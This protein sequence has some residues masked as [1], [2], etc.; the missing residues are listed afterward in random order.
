MS[1][2]DGDS[3]K[4]AE[5][6]HRFLRYVLDQ[7]VYSSVENE[8]E[9]GRNHVLEVLDDVIQEAMRISKERENSIHGVKQE[10]KGILNDNN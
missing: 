9:E 5:S 4:I 3:L 8:K 2:G 10:E 6:V 1:S 7:V